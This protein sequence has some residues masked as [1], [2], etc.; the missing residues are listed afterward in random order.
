MNTPHKISL[1]LPWWHPSQTGSSHLIA[2]ISALQ[3][4]KK[5]PSGATI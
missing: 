4:V 2:I 5:Y 1:E 3:V